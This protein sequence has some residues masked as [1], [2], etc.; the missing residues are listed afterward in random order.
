MR[1]R[2]VWRG[3]NWDRL[4]SF[5]V[6]VF[7]FPFFYFSPILTTNK[8]FIFSLINMQ[9][10]K[11]AAIIAAFVATAIADKQL[12]D[13]PIAI[14]NS[15]G[16]TSSDKAT[17]SDSPSKPT[18]KVSSDEEE[19]PTHMPADTTDTTSGASS[20]GVVGSAALVAAALALTSFF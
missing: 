12:G 15:D 17:T 16:S 1:S 11:A 14:V 10:F 8:Q 4:H 20:S 9:Q 19:G 13:D 18:D 7:P 3:K 2:T 5:F 6:F